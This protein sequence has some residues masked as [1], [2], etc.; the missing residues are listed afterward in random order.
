MAEVEGSSP[1]SS[2]F[3]MKVEPATAWFE[4]LAPSST[5]AWRLAFLNSRHT[6]LEAD[7]G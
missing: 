5:A 7:R 2:I 6:A 3:R 1:S 4:C